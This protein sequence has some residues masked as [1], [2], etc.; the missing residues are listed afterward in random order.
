[1]DIRAPQVIFIIG[2]LVSCALI[3]A[4]SA[5]TNADYSVQATTSIETAERTVTIQGDSY[6]VTSIGKINRGETLRAEVRRPGDQIFTVI[7]YNTD[8]QRVDSIRRESN[9]TYTLETQSL[10]K[11]TYVLA[12]DVGG[13]IR[14]IQPVVISGHDFDID[15]PDNVSQSESISVTASVTNDPEQVDVVIFNRSWE[16]TAT[17]A[18]I[19]DNEYNSVIDEDLAPGEYSLYVGARGSDTF[20]GERV[21]DGVSSAQSITV[22]GETNPSTT[23][24]TS[25]TQSEE[26]SSTTATTTS[27]SDETT[28][29][30]TPPTSTRTTSSQS[31]T[32]QASATSSTELLPTTANNTTPTQSENESSTTQTGTTQSVVTP[33]TPDQSTQTTNTPVPGFTILTAALAFLALILRQR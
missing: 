23:T 12:L 16:H 18:R 5:T 15:A 29:G 32:S 26:S 7:L 25:T 3:G 22:E 10:D 20:D 17:A 9:G 31:S 27:Q 19:G 24:D 14:T 4:V 21:L 13:K 8:R 11:G 30:T 6:E 33:N 2:I 1:M 28:A